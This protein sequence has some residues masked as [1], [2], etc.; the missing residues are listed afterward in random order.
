MSPQEQF[1]IVGGG[2]L[3]LTLALRLAR[4]GHRVTVLEAADHLGG[5][6]DAWQLGDVTWDRHYHVTLLS[7]SHIRRVLAELSLDDQMQWVQ[8]RTG[9]MVD[10]RLHSLSSS[11]EFLKFP[12][13][14]LV[15]KFR[16]GWTIWYASKLRDWKRLENIPVA[17]WLTKHSGRR[18]F[19]RIW[20]PLLKAKLGS[21]Y[22]RTSAAFIWTTIARMYAARRTGLKKELFGYLPGGYSRLLTAFRQ[23]LEQLG[24]EIRT[25]CAVKSIGRAG[26]VSLPVPSPGMERHREATTTWCPASRSPLSI[27]SAS[28][29][30]LSFDRVI[31]T[32][33]PPL[34]AR[35]CPQLTAEESSKLQGVEYLG[36]VCASV[37]LAKP[38]AGYYV[39]NITD[40]SPFT[41]IIEMSALVDPSQFGGRHLVYLPKYVAA[42]DP[43]CQKSDAEVETAFTAELLRMYP[44][45]AAEDVLAFRVSRVKHVFALPTLGYSS[46][47]PPAE[48]SVP[49][50]F[51]VNSSQIVNGTL[52]VN[53]T[54]KLAEESLP[55]V[56]QPLPP[57]TRSVSEA[58]ALPTRSVSEG[59]PCAP[60]SLNDPSVLTSSPLPRHASD[61]ELVARPG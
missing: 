5:L 34:A 7:D 54:V 59:D 30:S 61:R 57:P 40:E 52:N 17:D 18:A 46:R 20:L 56:C 12:P 37:L 50:L 25:S 4:R 26:G 41:G 9:F 38:L 15:D 53:E 36:I 8:T 42:G 24:V 22:E 23:H 14:G 29:Q 19:E 11:W 27:E 2:L 31:V 35:L 58:P 21:A 13:L 1:G 33:A 10:G 16:L 3:G 49:G 47:V 60:H 39:T 55:I 44:H 51:L 28:G 6:A 45:L 48:T 32:A 43:L